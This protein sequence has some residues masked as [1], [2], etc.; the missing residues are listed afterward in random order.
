MDEAERCD[1]LAADA[2]RADRRERLAGRAARADRR[3]TTSRRRSSPWR[4]GHE[5]ARHA[6]DRPRVAP[7]ARRDPGRWRSSSSCRRRCWRS[8]YV[9]DGQPETFDRIGA[10]LV[11]LFPLILMFLV[12]SIAM[13]RERTSGTLERLMSM[14]L[15][16]LDLLLGYGLAFAARR[17]GAGGVT[18]T[19]AFGLL[20]AR[21]GR[22]GVAVVALAVAQRRCSAWRSACS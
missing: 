15:A 7:A 16:K 20:G 2:R 4:S 5:P 18:A 8:S 13:L 1:E 11:G 19:V 10:P 22:L 6:R 14:P 17:R 3:A 21:D 9:F 12:T